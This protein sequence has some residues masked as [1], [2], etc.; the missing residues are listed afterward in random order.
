MAPGR[1]G[2][3]SLCPCPWQRIPVGQTLVAWASTGFLVNA[4]FSL[5]SLVPPGVGFLNRDEFQ[6][7]FFTRP[8]WYF[9]CRSS[10]GP[11]DR[12]ARPFAW[13][14]ASFLQAHNEGSPVFG[15]KAHGPANRRSPPFCWPD[16]FSW[17]FHI[18]LLSRSYAILLITKLIL[19]L[20]I[21]LFHADK[22][23]QV[24]NTAYQ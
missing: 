10:E 19:T 12:P 4:Q 2:P 5:P 23:W 20:P 22:Q 7:L 6:T 8:L 24:C 14:Q 3:P 11:K 18:N 9:P 15:G 13:T 21:L 16:N 17:I 1:A